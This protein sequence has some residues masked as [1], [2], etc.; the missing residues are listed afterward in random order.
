MSTTLQILLVED[1]GDTRRV[2]GMLLERDGHR[3]RTAC[4]AKSA[5]EEAIQSKPNVVLLDIGLPGTNGY[6]VVRELRALPECAGAYFIAL[7][8][9]GQPS[10][11][12]R[13]A[14][15]GFDLHMLKPVDPARL[16]AL[17]RGLPERQHGSI[18]ITG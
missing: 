11:G 6:G 18:P 9:F 1:H 10:D 16:L 4:D 14:A 15:A 5:L 2:L 3:V 12:G 13:F 17:L 8:G 7:T